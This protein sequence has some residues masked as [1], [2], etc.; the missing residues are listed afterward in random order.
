MK[1]FSRSEKISLV[2]IFA[3]LIIVSIPNFLIS[4]RRARDQVR[5][6]DLG[7]LQKVLGEYLADFRSYPLA[8]ADNLILNCISPGEIPVQNEKGQWKFNALSCRWGEDAF[9]NQVTKRVY[10]STLPRDPKYEEGARY[11]Y[12]SDGDRYQIYAAM[13]GKDE[14]E[15]DPDIVARNLACGSKICNVG[16]AYNVPVGI[17]IEKFVKQ[18][19]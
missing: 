7:A 18:L 9:V 14:A 2:V 4:L 10:M 8:S 5:R 12:L 17:S 3:V 19:K 15:I 6:D 13:E 11:L 16:R 1:P